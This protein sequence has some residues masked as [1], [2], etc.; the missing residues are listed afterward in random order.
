MISEKYPSRLRP[1]ASF[2]QQC[3]LFGSGALRHVSHIVQTLAFTRYGIGFGAAARFFGD[4]V[5]NDCDTISR[6]VG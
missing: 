1:C 3:N 2:P 4:L 5:W 6:E